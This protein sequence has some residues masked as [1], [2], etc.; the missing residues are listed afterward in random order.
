V[1]IL[2]TLLVL[3]IIMPATETKIPYLVVLTG[4]PCAGKTTVADYLTEELG[5]VRLSSDNLRETLYAADC[6]S[7]EDG[8]DSEDKDW[9][10]WRTLEDGRRLP[11]EDSELKDWIMWRILRES[12]LR[13][14]GY[15][16]D[17]VIDSSAPKNEH[18]MMLLDTTM[19]GYAIEL[20]ADKYL[21]FLDVER[22]VIEQRN[23]E[24]YRDL[25]S[26]KYWDDNWEGQPDDYL[27]ECRVLTYQNNT[28]EQREAMLRELDKRF[29][30]KRNLFVPAGLCS[31]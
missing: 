24:K 15:G 13:Y 11:I 2:K 3:I 16:L 1:K 6:L 17:V 23:R 14:L 21:L 20:R 9:T 19:P 29:R 30:R 22:D 26:L 5:F 25:G 12:K 27:P 18:R 7:I 10:L 31:E 4:Y 8:P 28:P